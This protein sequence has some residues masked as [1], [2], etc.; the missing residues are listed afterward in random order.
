[1][2]A[3]ASK[4]TPHPIPLPSGLC[5]VCGSQIKWAFAAMDFGFRRGVSDEHTLQRSVRSEQRSL[6]RKDMPPGGLH[7][8][9]LLARRDEGAY[10]QRS[11]T[12]EQ[13]SQMPNAVQPSGRH[14]FSAQ[15][16]L[17]APYRPLKGMLD[18]HASSE[19]KIHC[20][21]CPLNL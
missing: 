17:F 6:S 14:V 11:V 4:R 12:E 1:M 8:I 5:L 3:T 20:R 7:R 21:K 9:W 10:P 18:A 16:S 13:Q 15:T 2:L 19:P